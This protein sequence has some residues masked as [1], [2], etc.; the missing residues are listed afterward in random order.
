[1]RPLLISSCLLAVL[2]SAGDAAAAP[3]VL[4]VDGDLVVVDLGAADGLGEGSV[5]ELLHEVRVQDPVTKETLD[6]VFALGILTVVRAGEHVAEARAD[7]AIARRVRVGDGVR[8]E[9]EA[10]DF[11][12]PWAARVTRSRVPKVARPTKR[13]PPAPAGDDVA[14]QRAAAAAAAAD[15]EAV[16]EV[17]QQTLG[18]PPGERV[19]LWSQ[20][21]VAD[22]YNAHAETITAE[23]ASLT[24]QQAALDA[25]IA[26]PSA[27]RGDQLGAALSAVDDVAGH[28][29]LAIDPPRHARSGE[30][31]AL[32]FAMRV[33]RQVERA[34]LY[35]RTIGDAAYQRHQ[36][37]GDGDAYLRGT[38]PAAL[39]AAPGVEWFVEVAAPGGE[40]REAIGGGEAPR[41][42]EVADVR[43]PPA[44][45]P[46]R[47]RITATLD[48]VDFD[49]GL[50][51]GFDQ[52]SQAEL[53]FMYRFGKPIHAFRLGFGTLDG[54]GGP[55][56]VIDEDPAGNCRDGTGAG[57]FRCR[58]VAFTYAYVEAEFKVK[59]NVALM[60]RPQVG[61]LVTASAQGLGA[62]DCLAGDLEG[63]CEIGRGIGL[64][65]R[66][67]LG[68]ET[69]THL[70]I[71]VGA[72]SGVGTLFEAAYH[73]RPTPVVPVVLSVQVTDMPVP[74]DFGV[75]IIGD[76][77]FRKLS[78]VYPSL[79]LSY[80]ARDVDHAGFSGGLGLNFDW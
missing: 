49:G 30:P 66:I 7:K 78:W 15:A 62:G 3:V 17:W 11:D 13:P 35:A 45:V 18:R 8:L 5:L 38:I 29:V 10:R 76:V 47:S 25:A 32:A 68:A 37:V 58:K 50:Q 65:G 26:A 69:S 34:W 24:A 55:K 14:Q 33:P 61:R 46:G 74:E 43:E 71:S 56:D 40:P 59:D 41:T 23:I 80:Q 12:D 48:Y 28:G 60:I 57:S 27:D 9:S 53:D 19:A 21:L 42:I 70:E 64:R 22:P 77:G 36:L 54:K 39:V 4:S 75:R 67:R 63:A 20:L 79:R 2:L 72:T 1:M 52:Y 73:W 44:A 6:D 51:D 16:R 31:L